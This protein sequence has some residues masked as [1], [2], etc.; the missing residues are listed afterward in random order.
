MLVAIDAIGI[1]GHGGAAVLCELLHWLPVVR[2]TWQFHV[3]LLDRDLCEF[4]LPDDL[5]GVTVIRTQESGRW[6]TR[7][8]WVDHTFPA[9]AKSLKA[10][11]VLA[12]ANIGARRPSCPQVVFFQHPAV[13]DR[14]YGSFWN[15][16]NRLRLAAM[17]YHSLAGFKA[18]CAVLVQIEEM[19]KS[20]LPF[21][22]PQQQQNIHVIPSGYRTASINPD[23]RHFVRE[24]IDNTSHPRLIYVSFP[25]KHKNFTNLV[26]AMPEVLRSFPHA[27]LL[28]T[29]DENRVEGDYSSAVEVIKRAITQ[30]K[31]NDNVVMLGVLQGDEVNYALKNSDLLVFPSVAES[32]GLGL[33]EAMAVGCPV[34]AADLPYAHDVADDAACYFDPSDPQLIAECIVALLKDND[35]MEAMRIKGEIRKQ[36]YSYQLIAEKIATVFIKA[37]K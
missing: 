12:F 21:F 10:D 2:P 3:F 25:W 29:L 32:F 13:F 1:R 35:T 33:V 8:R 30:A 34:A 22:P 19:R 15:F 31:V 5:P 37:L 7:M 9:L 24:R 4:D 18:S 23:I 14:K 20:L 27:S 16:K 17:R 6:S 26:L 28:L 36:I 11:I